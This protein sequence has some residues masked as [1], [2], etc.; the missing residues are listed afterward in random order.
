MTLQ[1]SRAAVTAGAMLMA[2]IM[3]FAAHADRVT[4]RPPAAAAQQSPQSDITVGDTVPLDRIHIVTRPG[5]YGLS[6]PQQGDS[7]AIVSGQLVRI[8]SA[9]GKV[10]SALRQIERILD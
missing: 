1:Q 9:S 5:A 8:D 3:G 4:A 2:V 6:D 7:Y 10:L